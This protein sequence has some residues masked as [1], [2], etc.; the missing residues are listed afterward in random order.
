M[1]LKERKSVKSIDEDGGII[2]LDQSFV[3]QPLQQ[4]EG[5]RD[6]SRRSL[7]STSQRSTARD[8]NN[9]KPHGNSH[10]AANGAWCKEATLWMLVV[11]LSA[12]A[13]GIL[14]ER[15]NPNY[16]IGTLAKPQGSSNK[17]KSGGM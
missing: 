1:T 13:I 4:N 2:I 8:I 12:F 11:M 9:S 5:L 6:L 17:I 7:S 15:N 16:L 14:V 10:K 3:L